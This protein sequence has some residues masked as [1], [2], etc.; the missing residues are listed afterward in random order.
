M[1]ILKLVLACH[2]LVF[3]DSNFHLIWEVS[4]A[5]NVLTGG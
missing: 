5:A 3:I 4:H 2:F 1:L